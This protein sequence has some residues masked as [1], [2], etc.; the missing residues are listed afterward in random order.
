MALA[1]LP[2]R[3]LKASQWLNF[4]WL[5]VAVFYALFTA[6]TLRTRGLFDYLGS[7][8]LAFRASADISRAL[9]FAQVYDLA[10][11]D[12]YQRPLFEAY[13]SG[14][15]HGAYAP[16]PTPFLPPFIFM[17][18]PL[19]LLAPVPGFVAW[20]AVN[21]AGLALYLWRFTRAV[22]LRCREY[23]FPV[24]LSAPAF[25]TLFFGQVNVWLLVCLGEFFL[26]FSREKE[27]RSGLWLSGLL[28]KPQMLVLLLPG[29]L[30]GRR[31]RA[32]A[33]FAA[34]GL[35]IGVLSLLLAG[36]QGTLDLG[37]LLLGYSRGLATNNPQVM[38]NWR[39][40]AVNLQAVLPGAWAWVAAG[41]GMALTAALGLALW[42]RPAALPSVQPGV[43]LLGTYAATC[44]AT[45][46]AHVSAALPAVVLLLG[47]R[48]Q[49][50]RWLV[51]LWLL[52]PT[53]LFPVAFLAVPGI[54]HNLVGLSLLLL[55]LL[56]VGWASHTLWRPQARPAGG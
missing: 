4:A 29:L 33:G 11:Q 6:G 20:T 35:V 31:F 22:G 44:A 40:L 30:I 39:S 45:W 36:P 24:L 14:P 52:I 26:A 2:F 15:L 1:T 13:A 28:L 38:V 51:N 48:P 47:V 8:Y 54:A 18:W 32:L 53:L 9:G 27:F 34:A 19:L 56:L 7:D 41:I 37:R 21:A 50:P 55:N 43:A 12:A 16:V 25:A 17:L 46:H 42:F 23:L 3:R 10:T 5:A 49:V